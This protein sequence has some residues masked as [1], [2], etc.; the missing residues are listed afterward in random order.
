MDRHTP[1]GI[2]ILHIQVGFRPRAAF[3]FDP[4]LRFV[5]GP[6]PTVL[7]PR[8]KIVANGSPVRHCEASVRHLLRE[9]RHR[10]E[11]AGQRR[12]GLTR[13]TKRRTTMRYKLLGKSGLR[14]SELCLGTMTF[15]EDWGWGS[16]KEESRKVYDAFLEAGGNFIDTANVYTNGTSEK[17]LGE[18][19][20][21]PPGAHRPGDEVHQR[22]SRHRPE[23]RWQPA[24]EHG[25][26]GG[27]QPQAAQDRL[28]RPL[29]APHLGP[30]HAHRRS[31]AG[32]RRPRAAR[33]KSS[34]PASRTC[35]PG[36]WRRPTRW[37]TC[38]G[39]RRSWD[40][41]SNTA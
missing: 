41:K 27:G 28:H 26:G 34:T 30:D 18:F 11:H 6:S 25:A 9:V 17:L 1:F 14:V 24:Q 16:S 35:P 19:M 3:H 40:F 10:A 31:H 8:D 37:P 29:L 21:G 33:A 39:G 15:G 2:V 7:F 38:E 12:D 32:L 4:F 20:A 23:R 13:I 22:R 5:F 36:S